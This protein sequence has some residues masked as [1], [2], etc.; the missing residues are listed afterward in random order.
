M[1]SFAEATVKYAS[2]GHAL[3][4]R[5]NIS[6]MDLATQLSLH[7]GEILLWVAERRIWVEV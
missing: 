4:T 5:A 6:V 7:A 3:P 1:H 2:M